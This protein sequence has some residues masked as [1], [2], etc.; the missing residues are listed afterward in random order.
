[1]SSEHAPQNRSHDG[2][3]QLC[4]FAAAALFVTGI[5]GHIVNFFAPDS[6]NLDA[7][8][9]V[10]LFYFGLA[11]VDLRITSRTQARHSAEAADEGLAR[12]RYNR[13]A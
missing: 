12:P 11:V 3:S 5:G 1:M 10:S 4:F 13:A 2:N 9:L 6:T 7:L 8:L